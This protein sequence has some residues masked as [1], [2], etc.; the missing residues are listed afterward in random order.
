MSAIL[1]EFETRRSREYSEPSI[2]ERLATITAAGAGLYFAGRAGLRS[3]VGL[4]GLS[5]LG[6]GIKGVASP[7]QAFGRAV[8]DEFAGV[9][10]PPSSKY[11]TFDLARNL[12]GVVDTWRRNRDINNPA[13]SI[14][15]AAHFRKGLVDKGFENISRP[16]LKHLTP[17]TVGDIMQSTRL[18]RAIGPQSFR[19][20]NQARRIGIVTEQM[21][22]SRGYGGL[23]KDAAGGIVDTNFVNPATAAEGLGKLFNS[24]RV[25]FTQVR[26]AQVVGALFRP[27]MP[28]PFAGEIGQGIPLTR[29]MSV[30]R[31]GRNLVVNGR[32]LSDFGTG[33]FRQIASGYRLGRASSAVG[34]AH[35]ERFGATQPYIG[36]ALRNRIRT[37][38]GSF[39]DH[40]QNAAGV[41]PAYATRKWAPAEFLRDPLR[42]RDLGKVEGHAF[43]RRR[44]NQGWFANVLDAHRARAA[45]I[46][47][48]AYLGQAVPRTRPLAWMDKV[49]AYFGRSRVASVIKQSSPGLHGPGDLAVPYPERPG[50]AGGTRAVGPGE[51]VGPSRL[52]QPVTRVR[53]QFYAYKPS[54][55]LL[56][57]G[58]M[59][60]NRL[61]DLIGYTTGVGF[62]PSVG[63]VGALGRNLAKIYGIYAGASAAVG[64]AG[65]ADYA[66]ES[67][68]GVSPKK[69]ALLGYAGLR[70]GQQ[71]IRQALGIGVASDYA[72]DLF[73]KSVDSG[74][75][76]FAR[77]VMPLALGA[78]KS[79]TPG[80][81]AGA[82]VA[83]LVGGSD[84]GQ[85]PGELWQE[86]TG[87]KL[88]PIRK[89]RWWMLGRQPFEGGQIDHYAPHWLARELSEFRFTDVQYGSK[90]EYYAHVASIPLPILG[91]LPLPTPTNLFGLRNLMDKDPLGGGQEYLAKKHRYDRPY[92]DT[93]GVDTEAA[94]VAAQY[95]ASRGPYDPPLGAGERLGMGTEGGLGQAPKTYNGLLG[96]IV[97][98]VDEITELGGI[99]KFALWDFP[100]FSDRGRPSLGSASAIG[101][102][103]REYHDAQLG[104][105]LGMT[106]L[107]RRFVPQPGRSINPMVNMMPTWLPGRRS[108]FGEDRSFHI[109]F[110]LGDP[111]ASMKGGEYRLPGS[112]YEAMHRL[113]SETPGV[114]D[115]MDRFLILADVAPTS[116]AYREYKAIVDSWKKAGVLDRSWAEKAD[117]T[118]EQVRNKQERY[119]FTH[120]RFTGLITDP[121]P[122]KTEAKYNFLEKGLGSGWEM[123]THDL[124]PAFGDTV[125]IF[126]P[127][128]SDKMLV[129]RSPV[130]QYMRSEL[131]GEEFADWRSPWKAWIRPKMNIIASRDPISATA[132]GAGLGFLGAN[133]IAQATLGAIGATYGL[134]SSSANRNS[135]EPFIPGHRGQEWELLEYFDT[136]R[137]TKSRL[138]NERS[139]QVGDMELADFYEKEISRTTAGIN[140]QQSTKDYIS[141]SLRGL[142]RNMKS[143]FL[144]FMEMP[145]DTQQAILPYLPPQAQPVFAQSWAR[146][147]QLS[148]PFKRQIEADYGWMYDQSPDDRAA[149]FYSEN[150]LPPAS[151]SGWHPDVPLD[152][153]KIKMVDS[154]SNSVS[155]DIHKFDLFAE[156]RFR[157]SKFADIQPIMGSFDHVER[158]SRKDA[159]LQM[160]LNE[161]GFRGVRIRPWIGPYTSHGMSWGGM[162][163]RS[164]EM[165]QSVRRHFR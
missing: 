114:Y 107:L 39:I 70:L 162:Y 54:D 72:E 123:L 6:R 58:H 144:P 28:A 92:P 55:A 85:S 98:G 49:R 26:P 30:P 44:D 74:A 88:V 45:G 71:S 161:A 10:T 132:A 17:L 14:G 9:V 41:G 83:G 116:F 35:F 136:L 133:P 67:V 64:Y 131:Y 95:L 138:L 52:G 99:H 93:P 62:R 145:E 63:G 31:G 119:E 164:E 117:A 104:G 100:G 159:D 103:A 23:F 65:Y 153:V 3:D 4:R 79:G 81:K 69:T 21:A 151:W 13:N 87:D 15:L 139:Q 91:A 5:Q 120:R 124:I 160:M 61:N 150:P 121:K 108:E 68:T 53:Q 141:S 24:I 73:P 78:A 109:D 143:Y 76:W 27:L 20:L 7:I 42:R 36:R 75:S 134:L 127:M 32:V 25:P 43:V 101:S 96:A 89:A 135:S 154:G 129:A 46:D 158:P 149:H 84:P 163:D 77:T 126:G 148:Q 18:Q 152:A 125:P 12:E 19:T 60:T 51:M 40:I 16:G 38:K 156:H 110:T 115:A 118:L 97:K 66:M 11:G 1:Q 147:G 33:Q 112:G 50:F 165:R 34:Q 122:D 90:S 57:V 59:L 22:L 102:S 111:Y 47:P 2:F 142:P 105:G 86:Y 8:M 128:L 29:G 146:T 157:A 106:E 155:A 80:L 56:D 113:H 137:Y 48:D 94:M 82:L 130:E 37:G 140:Y